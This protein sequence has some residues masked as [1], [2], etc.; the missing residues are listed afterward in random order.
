MEGTSPAMT[1]KRAPSRG[2]HHST[3][4]RLQV[5]PK[6]LRLILLL[7]HEAEKGEEIL[8][9]QIARRA[10]DLSLWRRQVLERPRALGEEL[11]GRREAHPV[12]RRQL[13]L[14]HH[15]AVEIGHLARADDVELLDDEIGLDVI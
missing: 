5:I 13:F 1:K 4:Q 14:R 15:L 12:F 10:R 7:A 8:G 11:E 6:R 9:P 3:R 2:R